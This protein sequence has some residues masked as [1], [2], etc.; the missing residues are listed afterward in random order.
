MGQK[1]PSTTGNDAAARTLSQRDLA[2]VTGALER[3][4]PILKVLQEPIYLKE[5]DILEKVS[6]PEAKKIDEIKSL[7]VAMEVVSR[8]KE[9]EIQTLKGEIQALQ[10]KLDEFEQQ[11]EDLRLE[12]E[13]VERAK[14]ENKS[15]R[16]SI[17]KT[18]KEGMSK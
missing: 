3:L 9:E 8:T 14:A 16:E 10:A 13:A 5:V 4:F 17:D 12:K 1:D 11:K 15:E 6:G 18:L 2:S 7:T